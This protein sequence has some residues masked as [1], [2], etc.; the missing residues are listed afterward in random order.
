MSLTSA[1]PPS[2]QLSILPANFVPSAGSLLVGRGRGS[3]GDGDSQ[4]GF[5]DNFNFP[6]E[7]PGGPAGTPQRPPS[8]QEFTE[9]RVLVLKAGIMRNA[10]FSELALESVVLNGAALAASSEQQSKDWPPVG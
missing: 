10:G 5:Q 9:H 7:W 1:A 8:S 6:S 2:G 4:A 3:L